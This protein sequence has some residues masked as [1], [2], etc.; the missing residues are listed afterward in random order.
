[1]THSLS[2]NPANPLPTW[3]SIDQN[4]KLTVNSPDL[5][6][7]ETFLF[8][9]DTLVAL[10]SQTY[11]Q[12]FELLVISKEPGE[13]NTTNSKESLEK[14][15]AAD[16]VLVSQVGMAVVAISTISTAMF[17]LSSLQSL[18]AIINIVQLTMLLPLTLAFIPDIVI[19]YLIGM[20]FV[21]FNFDFI[22]LR[23]IPIIVDMNFEINTGFISEMG[24]RSA[25]TFV[26]HI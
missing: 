18:W 16:G 26:N 19:Q 15:G 6:T 24:L 5:T 21:N 14:E 10:D 22:P 17:G 25:S 2:P 13:E 1:M 12:E 11:T 23:D 9:V 20:S 3:V 7:N 8:N 4:A